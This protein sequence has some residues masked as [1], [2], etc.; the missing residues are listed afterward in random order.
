MNKF[1]KIDSL[2]LKQ[3]F[4]SI[5]SIIT[6]SSS[7]PF[8]FPQTLTLQIFSLT[9]QRHLLHLLIR[10]HCCVF[11]CE[12][13]RIFQK[14]FGIFGRMAHL[15]FSL[16]NLP[17]C[18]SPE[19]QTMESCGARAGLR[20]SGTRRG[21]CAKSSKRQTVRTFPGMLTQRDQRRLNCRTSGNDG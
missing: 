10:S 21:T 3:L 18:F 16:W 15:R 14:G 7:I 13:A 20:P 2:I 4:S 6:T 1:K 11:F 17:L 9:I 19:I 5:L 8:S 12:C